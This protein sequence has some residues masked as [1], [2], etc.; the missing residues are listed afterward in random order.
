MTTKR[1]SYVR[2]QEPSSTCI[3]TIFREIQRQLS[4]SPYAAI[5]TLR[6]DFHKGVAILCGTVPTFHTRQ[7]ALALVMKVTGVEQVD[8]RVEVAGVTEQRK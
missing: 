1:I 4:A 7:V 5:K 8:D 6:C 3:N 2:S